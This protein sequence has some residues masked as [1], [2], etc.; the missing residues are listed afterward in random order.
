MS[1]TTSA[2]LLPPTTDSAST[3]LFGA[4]LRT[5]QVSGVKYIRYQALDAANNPR[6]KC[7]PVSFLLQQQQKHQGQTSALSFQ[8]QFASVVMAGLPSFGDYMQADSGLD[9]RGV[10]SLEPDFTTF[11]VLPYAPSAAV[12]LGNLRDPFQP[13]PSKTSDLCC[14]S[15]L[16]RLMSRVTTKHGIG[17]NVGAELEVTLYYAETNKPVDVCNFAHSHVL[18]SQQDFLS[19]LHDQLLQQGI[20]VENVLSESGPGQLEVVLRYCPDPVLLAD[21]VFL[22]RETISALARTHGL[23]AVFLPK[24]DP[25]KAGNGCHLHLSMYDLKTGQNLFPVSPAETTQEATSPSMSIMGQSFMEG[26]LSHLP[27]LLALTL[28][29]TNSFRRVGPGCWTGSSVNWSYDDK[30]SPLRVVAGSIASS[31]SSSFGSQH[32]M[33]WNH[34]EYKLCDNTANLYLALTGIVAC[35]IRGIEHE[36]TLRP[37]RYDSNTGKEVE[38]QVLLSQTVTESLDLLENNPFLQETIP[39]TLLQ[40]YLSIRR[41]EAER[42]TDMTLADE[43]LEAVNAA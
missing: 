19:T 24:I 10:V 23:K 27:S 32:S 29:T 28:P 13:E 2:T 25:M 1:S 26:I 3:A 9:A 31:S 12:V 33:G 39:K 41:A 40:G 11:V 5:L 4:L 38:G 14:R 17:I 18:N 43:V 37:P 15:L 20:V 35:G 36:M 16:Q 42:G 34:V 6:I 8:V 22:A 7:V 21:K 30:E